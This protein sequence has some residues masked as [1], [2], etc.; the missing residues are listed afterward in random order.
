[1]NIFLIGYYGEGNVG[2]DIFVKQL[3]TFW[4]AQE[5]VEQVFVMC[6][7]NYYD[8]SDSKIQIFSI[9]KLTRLH[10]LW[11]I[12]KSD[13]IVWGG[14]SLNL[15]IKPKY[16]V[17]LQLLSKLMGKR[18]CFIGVGLEGVKA[19]DNVTQIY[20]NADFLYVRD[21]DSYQVVQQKIKYNKHFCMGGDL[22]FLN[23]NFYE[24]YLKKKTISNNI[25]NISFS[26]TYW[27]GEGRGKFYAEQLMPLIEKF[28][29]VIHLLPAHIGDQKND[30]NFHKFLKKYLPEQNCVIHSW[31]KPEEFI[32]ILS[33][34]DFHL[35]NR[36]HSIILADILGVPNIGIGNHPSKISNYINKTEMLTNERIADFMEPLSLDRIMNIFQ[37][38]KRPEEFIFNESK[39]SK[40]GLE[41]LFNI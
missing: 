40:E 27:W 9:H 3:T 4:K 31:N 13:Y 34:M 32:E 16:L 1:M 11:L 7:N 22:A 35:G 14:G 26:G 23:L 10:R 41:K 20:K 33:K 24:K 30:N 18:F 21:K 8:N 2:D 36:L 12:L 15:S 38:Y 37:T 6:Q 5:V 17:R 25:N 29:S 39:T 28:N 19:E